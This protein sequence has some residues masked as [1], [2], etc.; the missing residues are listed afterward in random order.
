MPKRGSSSAVVG[1][2]GGS[3]SVRSSRP[4]SASSSPHSRAVQLERVVDERG[5]H[6]GPDV[7]EHLLRHA[8]RREA[9]RDRQVP[10][11]AELVEG[12]LARRL[13]GAV[14]LVDPQVLERA[15]ELAAER[16]L[17]RR[18]AADHVA[19]QRVVQALALVRQQSES[20]LS[21]RFGEPPH[22]GEYSGI[23]R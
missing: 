16:L 15:R 14:L 4:A 23:A 1:D 18:Q 12:R 6:D 5:A 20:A 9:E 3:P 2:R 21:G 22:G 17:A 13:P 11:G 10:A 8:E 19:L 7:D